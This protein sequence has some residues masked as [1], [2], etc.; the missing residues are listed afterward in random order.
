MAYRLGMAS[1]RSRLAKRLVQAIGLKERLR[2]IADVDEDPELLARELRRTRRA[3]RRTPTLA[4]RL[5]HSVEELDIFGFPMYVVTAKTGPADRVVFY[6]H[7]GGYMFGPFG[8][9]W[10]AMGRLATSSDSDFALLCYPRA[11]EHT[12]EQ[13]LPVAVA[14]VHLLVGRYGVDRV[15]PMGTSAGG[16]LALALLGALRDEG[17]P[18]PPCAILLS[19]GVDMTLEQDVGPLADADVLLTVEHVRS[20]GKLFGGELGA[21]HPIVSPALGE[22]SGL[23]P[24]HVFVG[25]DE[26][27]LPSIESFAARAREAGTEVHLVVGDGEQHTWPLAP[28]PEGRAALDQMAHIVSSAV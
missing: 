12:A 5:R 22:L 24:L 18:M 16:G 26:L 27:L 14:A 13:T 23:P 8:T 9:D 6:L 17:H 25:T 10:T 7:G 20:A 2:R 28:T 15:V 4:V 19:P 1:V 3:D 21:D 11:P